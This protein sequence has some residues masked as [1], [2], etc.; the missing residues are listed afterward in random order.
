MRTPLF[1]EFSHPYGRL[2]NAVQ[3]EKPK[4]ASSQVPADLIVLAKSCLA[5]KP[6]TR[7]KVLTWAEFRSP[8]ATAVPWQA[9][10][11]RILKRNAEV[12]PGEE[13]ALESQDRKE[14]IVWKLQDYAH[15]VRSLVRS[16]CVGSSFFPR[17]TIGDVAVI[18][19]TVACFCVSFEPS[20]EQH[21]LEVYFSFVVQASWLDQD[22]EI[23]C[24]KIHAVASRN[25]TPPP[26]IPHPDGRPIYQGNFNQEKMAAAL[27]PFLYA[28]LDAIQRLRESSPTWPQGAEHI[29]FGMELISE[30]PAPSADAEAL[31]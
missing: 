17:L 15:Q 23:V 27:S 29:A 12:T 10:K 16:E 20:P 22:D 30:S 8:Q 28:A 6:A 19:G 2:V 3:H 24:V 26:D 31:L 14:E 1:Q 11:K 4:I 13:P 7:L 25:G 5:K 18:G 21:G 9:V